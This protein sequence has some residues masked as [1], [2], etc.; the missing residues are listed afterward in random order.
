MHNASVGLCSEMG[1]SVPKSWLRNHGWER[2]SWTNTDE[3][4]GTGPMAEVLYSLGNLANR[5]WH[6]LPTCLVP[7]SITSSESIPRSPTSSPA[8]SLLT[9][10]TATA[11]SKHVSQRGPIY[12]SV[13]YLFQVFLS[14]GTRSAT[15]VRT[16]FAVFATVPI[17]SSIGVGM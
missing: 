16:R 8:P 2:V 3:K 14:E 17:A 15:G 1:Q 5:K 4:K 13:D 6:S 9:L 10:I 7:L 11:S 12:S